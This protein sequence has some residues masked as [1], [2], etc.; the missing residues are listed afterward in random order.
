MDIEVVTA[1]IGAEVSGLEL[2]AALDDVWNYTTRGATLWST[3]AGRPLYESVG[4]AAVA[5]GISWV[6][7]GYEAEVAALGHSPG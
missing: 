6:P 7:A 3:P 4:F 2:T 5:E 1:V